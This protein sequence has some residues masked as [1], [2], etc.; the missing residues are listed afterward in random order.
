MSTEENPASSS[1]LLPAT[2]DALIPI[3]RLIHGEHNP[4]RVQPKP[5][6]EESIAQRGLNHP[7]IVRPAA[8]SDRYHI[9]DGWQRYQAATASG[10]EE[11]PVEI[12]KSPVAALKATQADSIVTEWSTYDWARYCQSLAEEVAPD[13]PSTYAAAKQIVPPVSRSVQTVYQYLDVM[14]LPTEIHPLLTD[15]PDGNSQQW[16]ALQNYNADV[17]RYGDLW[18]EVAAAIVRGE[19]VISPGRQI[20]IAATAVKFEEMSLAK[21]F[22]EHA[23]G[24]PDTSLETI[25]KRVEF[26]SN[27][28]EYLELPC[29]SIPMEV[30]E[31]RALMDYCNQTR[32]PLSSIIEQSLKEIAVEELNTDS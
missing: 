4:R 27:H 9:T 7:L 21:E 30:S 6:L 16:A 13:A 25:R 3:E 28:T 8:D 20:G 5:M 24:E 2:Y 17:K 29:E 18:W 31:Q 1:T 22:V 19:T 26:G 12:Y 32:Q 11:L 15:G 10:W 23:R 14:S